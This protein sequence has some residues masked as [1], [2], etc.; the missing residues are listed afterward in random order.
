MN[1]R[2]VMCYMVVVDEYMNLMLC[3]YNRL[4]VDCKGEKLLAG[5][6]Y[7]AAWAKVVQ[8]C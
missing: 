7:G 1:F 2:Q 5:Q 6:N 8:A 4:S 3:K